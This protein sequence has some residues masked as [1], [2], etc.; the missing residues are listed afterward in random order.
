MVSLALALA[1]GQILPVQLLACTLVTPPSTNPLYWLCLPLPERKLIERI[2]RLAGRNRPAS[3][4]AGIGD[5]AA[6]LRV[7][8]GFDLLVTTDI[9]AEGVHFRRDWSAPEAIGHRALARGLSDIAAM[10]GEPF[11][12]FL[13]LGLSVR[14]PQ[15]WVDG[16]LAGF[17]RLAR[18]HAV[19]LAGGDTSGSKAG[20]VADVSVLGKVPAGRAIRRSGA[21]P[22]DVICVTGKLGGSAAHIRRRRTGRTQGPAVLPEPRISV[23]RWL[24]EQRL[25]TAMIDL[26][27][28]L[29]VD[30]R[31][32]CR[33][34]GVGAA[35]MESAVPRASG[36]T[37]Q[38]ALHGGE[39][40]ELLFTVGRN[41]KVPA[42]ITGVAVSAIGEITR[43][44]KR[45]VRI[46][47]QGK[48]KTMLAKG[49]EH[50][51]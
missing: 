2:R 45:D 18:K 10:G 5:D 40:Y 30:L 27:D 21:R 38:D 16:F 24:R 3:V 42:E 23:A 41:K 22:G 14:T 46:L 11:A 43:S 19:T 37:L 6:V 35:V 39:D 28:G 1:S 12:A 13:S 25:A 15:K 32:I 26:S 8:P 7:E 31:H 48:W 4:V 29:S 20:V 50:F 34:S 51:R 9:S 33:E 17:L 36:A 49:W 44:K 47:S